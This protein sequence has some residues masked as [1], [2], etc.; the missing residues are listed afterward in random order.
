M[1]EKR[2]HITEERVGWQVVLPPSWEIVTTPPL[3]SLP[4]QITLQIALFDNL[5]MGEKN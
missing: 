1:G 4:V 2:G 5:R 3:T